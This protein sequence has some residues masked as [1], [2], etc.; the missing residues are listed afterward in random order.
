MSGEA[1]GRID[2][3][4]YRH[5]VANVMVSPLVTVARTASL[6]DAAR[7]MTDKGVS[8]VLVDGEETGIVTERD[9]V[10][11]VARHG[12]RV[13]AEPV[14]GIAIRPVHGV[15]ADT[16][17]YVALGR[18]TR[19]G[20]RHLLAFD[21]AGH[22]VGMVTARALLK[23]RAGR[24]LALG[25][26]IAVARGA[27]DLRRVRDALPALAE[28]LL[29]DGLGARA[30]AAV[31][32]AVHRDMT[33]RAAELGAEALEADG[34]GPAPAPWCCLV[35]GS[36]GRGDSLLAADQDNA[37]IHGGA[38]GEPWFAALGERIA[39]TLDA[40]GLPLCQGGIMAARPAWR[41]TLPGWRDRIAR[42][43]ARA[44][45]ET[46]LAVDIFFD[47]VPVAGDARLAAT[48]RAEATTAARAPMLL[49][50]LA[51]ELTGFAP[52]IGLFGRIKTEQG[53][54][55]LK[56]NGLHP[57][58][59]AARVLA[60]RHGIAETTTAA[61]LE[62]A[63]AAGAI[64]ESDLVPIGATH[65]FLMRLVLEQQI[66]DLAAGHAPGTKVA[67]G[68]LSPYRIG[69]LKDAL[70]QAAAFADGIKDVVFFT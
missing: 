59:A 62:R 41:H 33:G 55:D 23:L 31:I 6:E 36:V 46:L 39:A 3:F 37:L 64:P 9:V 63:H 27:L 42:W 67:V 10:K 49:T 54:V 19:L 18:M 21:G 5:R 66:A 47:F 7:V 29:A 8:S 53:R 50:M 38:E 70:R 24:A 57:I 16:F 20:V 25:D 35:L 56:L 22:P 44:E 4:P 34:R 12:A 14:G 1:T 60:L 15:P 43:V 69:Q 48:L 32:S 65:E 26:E 28:G 11:A 68:A 52:P 40:A 13:L 61:R 51:H 2:G 58:V 30:I 17:I 45:C